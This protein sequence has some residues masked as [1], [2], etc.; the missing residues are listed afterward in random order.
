MLMDVCLYMTQGHTLGPCNPD[1]VF[2]LTMLFDMAI[3][4]WPLTTLKQLKRATGD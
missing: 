3:D 2:L 4:P 1:Q